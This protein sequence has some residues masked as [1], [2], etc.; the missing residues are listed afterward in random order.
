MQVIESERVSLGRSFQSSSPAKQLNNV[1]TTNTY[2]LSIYNM[3]ASTLT[4]CLFIRGISH[5]NI[6]SLM[7]DPL[8]DFAV[9]LF[10]W[11][12]LFFRTNY[13]LLNIIIY[14]CVHLNNLHVG[15]TCGVMIPFSQTYQTFVNF[16]DIVKRWST[17]KYWFSSH[18]HWK[19]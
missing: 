19:N 9:G 7:N 4:F 12:C 8:S 13:S 17:I 1:L 5:R 3:F 16:A 14:V 15:H 18:T 2:Y 10:Y 11:L 6:F